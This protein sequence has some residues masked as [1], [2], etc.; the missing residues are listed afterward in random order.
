MKNLVSVRGEWSTTLTGENHLGWNPNDDF[1]AFAFGDF[2]SKTIELGTDQC[3][4]RTSDGD[5]YNSNLS[6][7]LT[8][9]TADAPS[10]NGQYFFGSYHKTK[11]FDI[12]FAFDNLQESGLKKLKQAFDGKEIKQLCFSE[13]CTYGS[14]NTAEF[15]KIYNAKVTG[16]PTIKAVCFDEPYEEIQGE[17]T[18]IKIRKI[19]KGEGTVQFTAYWPYAFQAINPTQ[20]N[21]QTSNTGSQPYF[22]ITNQ[23]DVPTGFVFTST[24]DGVKKV[25]LTKGSTKLAEIEV[26]NNNN[27][28]YWDSKTGIVKDSS[29]TIYYS[30]CGVFE[31]PVKEQVTVT[32]TGPSQH[33]VSQY[34]GTYTNWYY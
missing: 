24:V 17:Q 10:G 5:R 1:I 11:V 34:I 32:V 27:I 16:Q 26:N 12:N 2:N 18:I 3:V 22:N 23:G 31:F 8:D 29:G 33:N 30:G 9:I 19:Y 20:L 13:D 14:Q 25:T 6:P 4:Y 7:Q 28:R 21:T 15:Y